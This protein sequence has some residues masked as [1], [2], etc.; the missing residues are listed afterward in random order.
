LDKH[1]TLRRFSA[2]LEQAAREL[3]ALLAEGSWRGPGLLPT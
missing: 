3:E 2:W 1:G